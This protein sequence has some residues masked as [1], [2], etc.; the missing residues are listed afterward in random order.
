MKLEKKV[1]V[2]TG[3]GKGIGKAT[4]TKLAEEGARVVISDIDFSFAENLAAKLKKM[5][6]ETLAVKADVSRWREVESLFKQTERKFGGVDILI[7][8]AGIRKDVPLHKITE[9]ATKEDVIEL[10][11][12]LPDMQQIATNRGKFVY[13]S[14]FEWLEARHPEISKYRRYFAA[15]ALSMLPDGQIEIPEDTSFAGKGLR[16][17]SP[18]GAGRKSGSPASSGD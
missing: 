17:G 8:N 7:N 6:R 1:A 9:K 12:V 3:A 10:M 16:R 5:G 14:V 18:F 11:K 13:K 15:G 4:A 2:V